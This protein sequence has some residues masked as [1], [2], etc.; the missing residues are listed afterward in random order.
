[1]PGEA[2]TVV[3]LKTLIAAGHKV[4]AVFTAAPLN[5]SGFRQEPVAGTR[6]HVLN[7]RHED[8]TLIENVLDDIAAGLADS[9][10]SPNAGRSDCWQRVTNCWPKQSGL[11]PFS[12]LVTSNP[13]S[14]SLTS[15]HQPD[16]NCP[17]P[18]AVNC[19]LKVSTEPKLSFSA[20]S[21]S[22]GIADLPGPI[23][24]QNWL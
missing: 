21:S 6:V 4:R 18:A 10:K 20:A 2:N 1:M 11:T 19:S 14:A 15:Q 9:Q 22:D 23:I 5:V 17:T 24:S 7:L 8:S 16:P 13:P 3:A 12:V